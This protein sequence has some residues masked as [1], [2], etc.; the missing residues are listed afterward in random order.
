M[1]ADVETMP[2]DLTEHQ[3]QA[4]RVAVGWRFMNLQLERH[5]SPQRVHGTLFETM[6]TLVLDRAVEVTEYQANVILGCLFARVEFLN[7]ELSIHESPGIRHSLE[8]EA[9][10]LC[11][12]VERICTAYFATFT[13]CPTEEMGGTA[14]PKSI[15]PLMSN[16]TVH[17][18][19]AALG[20]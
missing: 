20:G 11:Q 12:V 9:E 6:R 14:Q 7:L 3:F 19:W 5:A 17:D 15:W 16:G 4:L 2:L 1:A 8:S 10:T 18:D 13:V